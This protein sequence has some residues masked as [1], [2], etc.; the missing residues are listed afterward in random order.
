MLRFFWLRVVLAIGFDC[1]RH[2]AVAG[3][4]AS[5]FNRERRAGYVAEQAAGGSDAEFAAGAHIAF[6]MSGDGNMPGFDVG[7][8]NSLFTD[9]EISVTGDIPVHMPFN[10]YACL[11]LEIAFDDRPFADQRI[12]LS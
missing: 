1:G 4:C 7:L 9:R 12:G 6:Y 3:E 8:H 10:M 11:G 2:R 5:F